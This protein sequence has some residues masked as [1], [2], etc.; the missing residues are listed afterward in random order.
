MKKLI[1]YS[2][3]LFIVTGFYSC[4]DDKNNFDYKQVNELDGEILN[5]DIAGYEVNVG[6]ELTISP[7]FKF[8]IDKENPDVSYEWYLDGK[9]LDV[10]TPSYTFSSDKYGIYELTYAVVDNKTGVKFSL[11]TK[12]TVTSAYLKG[13]AILSDMNGRSA[14][15]F[16]KVKTVKKLYYDSDGREAYKDSIVYEEVEKD[17][18]PDLGTE[19]LRLLESTGYWDLAYQDL[20]SGEE[21]L[22]DELVVMQGSKWVELNGNS[23]MKSVYT[24]EE[25]NGDIPDDFSPVDAV[26]TY[27]SKFLFNQNGYIYYNQRAVANDFHAGFYLSDPIWGGT[28]FKKM[29]GIQKFND[30]M[31]TIPVLTTDNSLQYIWDGG[32]T[33]EFPTIHMNTLMYSG[34]VYEIVDDEG[35]GDSRFQNMEYEIINMLP[36]STEKDDWYDT[37]MPRWVAL[38]KKD[39]NYFLRNFSLD[40]YYVNPPVKVGDYFEKN[41]KSEMFADYKDMVVFQ[42]K[43]Y[44]VI[45]NGAELWYCSTTDEGDSGIK[46]KLEDGDAL[47]GEIV[48]LSYLD[49]N[50]NTEK[51]PVNGHLGVAFANGEFRIYEVIEQKAGDTATEVTLKKL[52]PNKVSNLQGDNKFGTIVDAI[53]KFGDCLKITVFKKIKVE[54]KGGEYLLT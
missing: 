45:A 22:Y 49:I 10:T 23:L 43:R 51:E 4:L 44:V 33:Y 47:P 50:F 29:Y 41:I 19:P 6:E 35:K 31:R 48:S 52:Y 18:I 15:S 1:I 3:L 25:F 24:E 27:S 30:Y 54:N 21:V 39:G 17:I 28:R 42:N 53:Y 34:N 9:K 11:S 13:W 12:I 14:L 46:I 8:T 16:I 2:L 36:A 20:N 40:T 7:T 5:I 32:L 37:C 26:M 38:L